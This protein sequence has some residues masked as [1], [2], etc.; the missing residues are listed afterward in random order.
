MGKISQ[1]NP[2]LGLAN[3]SRICNAD[4]VP[5]PK[6]VDADASFSMIRW[7]D[8]AEGPW[9][10]R[11]N[12][13]TLNGRPECVGLQIWC[14]ADQGC[15]SPLGYSP[16]PDVP[17]KS[18]T[19][20]GIAALPIATIID[21]LRVVAREHWQANAKQA[22]VLLEGK[23]GDSNYEVFSAALQPFKA[24]EEPKA[25]RVGAPRRY[26]RGHFVEVAWIYLKAWQAGRVNPTQAVSDHFGVSRTAAGKWVARARSEEFQLLTQAEHG[27]S[28][29]QAGPGLIAAKASTPSRGGRSGRTARARKRS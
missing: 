2:G 9:G 18:V 7:P 14:G 20:T 3:L 11:A 15:S 25:G 6:E 29:A 19:A 8:P 28:G 26:G 24:F 22:K 12:W 5:R 4:G 17:L 23:L 1:D 13:V 16:I 10:I 21:K 27:R